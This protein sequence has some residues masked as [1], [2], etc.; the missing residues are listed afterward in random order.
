M[1]TE[2]FAS[3][4]GPWSGKRRATRFSSRPLTRLEKA[5][6][7]LN[8]EKIHAACSCVKH[9]SS[10]HCVKNG[11]TVHGA[12]PG[13]PWHRIKT[14][15]GYLNSDQT[16]GSLAPLSVGVLTD[17]VFHYDKDAV[18]EGECSPAEARKLGMGM[19]WVCNVAWVICFAVY[20]G[21]HWTYP[22][23]RRQQLALRMGKAVPEPV[24]G[25]DSIPE[26]VAETATDRQVCTV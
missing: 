4:G 6:P 25:G 8:A 10:S 15:V 3:E 24:K 23:D 13:A 20:I 17:V 16:L 9:V 22:K 26:V 5:F 21:M 19:F 2:K 11:K 7:Q 14:K 1:P 18:K 12:V